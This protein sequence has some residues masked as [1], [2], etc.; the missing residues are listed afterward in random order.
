[1][2]PHFIYS[3][4]F[5]K[6]KKELR[7]VHMRMRMRAGMCERYCL[8]NLYIRLLP[9]GVSKLFPA[10]IISF[11]LDQPCVSTENKQNADR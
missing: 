9:I 10:A 1:M 7:D 2:W 5:Q 6:A 3:W 4:K 11:C 8:L